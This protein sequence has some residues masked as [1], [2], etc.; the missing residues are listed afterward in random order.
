MINMNTKQLI[1]NNENVT[2][3]TMWDEKNHKAVIR[4]LKND[5]ILI[6]DF[7]NHLKINGGFNNPEKNIILKI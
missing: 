2:G 3:I 4:C 7:I 1:K 5:E 6:E